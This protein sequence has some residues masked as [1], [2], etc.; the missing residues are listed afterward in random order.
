MK[1]LIKSELV[2]LLKSRTHLILIILLTLSTVIL[3]YLS[4]KDYGRLY[5][6]LKYYEN[7]SGDKIDSISAA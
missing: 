6:D 1:R 5:D 7:F 2:K 4:F 3:T